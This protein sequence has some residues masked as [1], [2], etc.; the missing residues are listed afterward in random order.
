MEKI[1]QHS[2]FYL[3]WMK[4]WKK[5]RDER[6]YSAAVLMDLP[7]AFDTINHHHLIAKQY[8]YGLLGTSL[9]LLKDYLSNGFQRTKVNGTL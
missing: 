1:M 7:K 5:F 8:A 3:N 2:M 6:G 9:K 4:I